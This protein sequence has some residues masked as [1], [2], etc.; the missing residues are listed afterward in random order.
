MPPFAAA[1]AALALA[2]AAELTV[3]PTDWPQFRGPNRNGFSPET[4]LL[5][6]WPDGGPPKVWTATGLGG[7]YGSVSVVGGVIFG[8]GKQS[9]GKE[10]VW[11]L[12]E[13]T[14]KPK[15][16]TPFADGQ[17]VGYG[18]GPRSTPTYAGGR[19]YAVGTG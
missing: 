13:A 19:V 16:S 3:K 2:P 12:D 6:K 15:W 8:T 10:Y 7:G 17:S 11:A 5:K 14:G 1:L 18:E 4:G 9:D